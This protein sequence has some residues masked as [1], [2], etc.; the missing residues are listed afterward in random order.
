MDMTSIGDTWTST[1][2]DF[3]ARTPT[4]TATSTSPTTWKAYN[5][6]LITAIVDDEFTTAP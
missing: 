3:E 4:S 1:A 5:T 6:I 2:T